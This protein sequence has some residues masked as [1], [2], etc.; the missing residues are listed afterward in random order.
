METALQVNK[1]SRHSK[2]TGDFAERLVLYWLSKYG[3]E[4]AYVDHVGMDIIARNPHT[5][6]V[7]GISVKSRSRNTGKE[8]TSLSIPV[9]HPGKL[10]DACREFH[11][12][13]YFAIVVDEADSITGFIISKDH[14][15]KICPP[16][17]QVIS[18]KMTKPWIVQC[19]GD[20]DIKMFRFLTKTGNWWPAVPN[21]TG[22]A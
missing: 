3:F 19:E 2:I 12:Q 22:T 6:E 18:W 15:L 10:E 14:L 9:G 7:M 16:G 8:G 21:P 1:S 20:K 13:P 17:E 5:P 11:C 4:C